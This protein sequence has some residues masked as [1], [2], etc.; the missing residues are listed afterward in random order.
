MELALQEAKIEPWRTRRNTSDKNQKLE[1]LRTKKRGAENDN[2]EE[3]EYKFRRE[4]EEGP[5]LE[6][7]EETTLGDTGMADKL[8]REEQRKLENSQ[9]RPGKTEG[10]QGEERTMGEEGLGG[11]E[12]AV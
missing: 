9:N 12:R 11:Q 8:P 5:G 10:S 4:K 7:E 3:L 1:Y 2:K 6:R